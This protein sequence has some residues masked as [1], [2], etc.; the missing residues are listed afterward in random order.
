MDNFAKSEYSIDI[1]NKYGSIEAFKEAY[2]KCQCS[3]QFSNKIFCGFRGITISK[4]D[5]SEYQKLQ[6]ALAIKD[7]AFL[8][9]SELE[10]NTGKYLDIDEFEN[11]LMKLP[12]K[13]QKVYRYYISLDGKKYTY[14]E[15]GNI[16][17]VPQQRISQIIDQTVKKLRHLSRS[18]NIVRDCQNDYEKIREYNSE[19]NNLKS[20]IEDLQIIN[21]YF[22]STDYKNENIELSKIYA[23]KKKLR[24]KNISNIQE[25][26][27]EYYNEIDLRNLGFSTRTYNCLYGKQINKL[28]DLLN[29]TASELYKIRN[30]GKST[31][32]EVVYKL[33]SLGLRL[34]EENEEKNSNIKGNLI[35][36]KKI[37]SEKLEYTINEKNKL[38]NK[39]EKYYK[40][41]KQYLN[42]EDIFNSEYNVSAI[43]LNKEKIED[44][45]NIKRELY[46]LKIISDNN[47]RKND[48]SVLKYKNEDNETKKN[49]PNYV[50]KNIEIYKTDIVKYEEEL[51]E[52]LEEIHKK[53]IYHILKSLILAKDEKNNK[54][55]KYAECFFRILY[56]AAISNENI[57][58]NEVIYDD[59][60]IDSLI[61][62]AKNSIEREEDTISIF[63]YIFDTYISDNDD[64]KAVDFAKKIIDRRSK[65]AFQFIKEIMFDYKNYTDQTY[66]NNVKKIIDYAN[67]KGI[68]GI[69]TLLERQTE[70]FKIGKEINITNYIVN[71]DYEMYDEEIHM[72]NIKIDKLMNYTYKSK[73]TKIE[74]YFNFEKIIEYVIKNKKFFI[75]KDY[76]NIF[77]YVDW[78]FTGLAKIESENVLNRLI[79]NKIIYEDIANLM[80]KYVYNKI[81]FKHGWIGTMISL[82][83]YIVNILTKKNNNQKVVALMQDYVKMI[84]NNATQTK[85]Q[86]IINTVM[87]CFDDDYYNSVENIEQLNSDLKALKEDFSWDLYQQFLIKACGKD[88]QIVAKLMVKSHAVLDSII[89]EIYKQY[90]IEMVEKLVN[91]NADFKKKFLINI[92]SKSGLIV[93][94]KKISENDA[95]KMLKLLLK[96]IYDEKNKYKII[97]KLLYSV[98]YREVISLQELE[99][100]H[101][102]IITINSPKYKRELLHKWQLL[103]EKKGLK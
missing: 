81:M 49:Q 73:D 18:K 41:I 17:G 45:D 64:I 13:N 94:V 32:N 103:S 34:K 100:I 77:D 65:L 56:N 68:K 70:V 87:H 20:E 8:D 82:R 69:N 80:K 39:I 37:K 22:S 93:S 91:A 75:N 74:D 88:Y 60:I 59:F 28:Y 4:N 61:D 78:Y 102:T 46:N 54:N 86:K 6:Y 76:N 55:D 99:Y 58:C 21:D 24:Q 79:D 1:M 67:T 11:I 44:I 98:N 40:A 85:M 9:I 27:Q 97:K 2:K 7:I 52:N 43:N 33:S 96:D 89:L 14:K 72:C 71:I 42:N 35:F 62:I 48:K 10:Y 95:F 5:M 29:L 51:T 90:G 19:I 92:D 57:L 15:I 26:M 47:I 12:E 23:N 53:Q 3:Y 38:E 63:S 36:I 66:I 30:C 16:I 84:Q 50:Y 31:Y 25:L 101:S 83:R